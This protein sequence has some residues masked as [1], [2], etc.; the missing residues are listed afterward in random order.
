MVRPKDLPIVHPRYEHRPLSAA[1]VIELAHHWPVV[2]VNL[3][4]PLVKAIGRLNPGV[5][6]STVFTEARRLGYLVAISPDSND[7]SEDIANLMILW[8]W[9]CAAAG[10]P[11]ICMQTEA[12]GTYRV[13]VDLGTTDSIWSLSVFRLF[14][15]MLQETMGDTLLGDSWL[16][17]ED[18]FEVNHLDHEQ[19]VDVTRGVLDICLDRR[20]R[21]KRSA[22]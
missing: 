17:T 10:R 11:E 15:R 4:D 9:W 14:A 18:V 1:E 21:V 5:A 3:D 19:A 12:E 6:M 20:F 8:S 16:F 7:R 22:R 2:G 13:R